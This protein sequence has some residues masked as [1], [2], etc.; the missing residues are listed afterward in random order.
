GTCPDK[1]LKLS[2][3]FKCKNKSKLK[4]IKIN[5]K[6]KSFGPGCQLSTTLSK[7]LLKFMQDCT[8]YFCT[9]I[10]FDQYVIWR[11]TIG[12]AT[13]NNNLIFGLAGEHAKY[14]CYLFFLYFYN[15]YNTLAG[16][17]FLF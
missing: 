7:P 8:N 13:I 4:T 16:V 6:L 9:L 15:T 5:Q 1:D 11:Y 10:P 2:G 12:S 17:P 14:W 3:Y